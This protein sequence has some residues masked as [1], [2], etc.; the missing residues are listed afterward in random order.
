[1]DKNTIL[2]YY[3]E[4]LFIR[5]PTGDSLYYSDLTN[6]WAKCFLG[7]NFINNKLLNGDMILL[8]WP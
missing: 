7:K 6:D 2:I 5:F 4:T 3:A 1:M 8:D